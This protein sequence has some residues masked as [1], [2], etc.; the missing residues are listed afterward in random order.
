MTLRRYLPV[1]GLL[2]MLLVLQFQLW[3]PNRIKDQ[4]Q[5]QSEE[6]VVVRERIEAHRERNDRLLEEIRNAH[7]LEA[8]EEKARL[9]LGMVREDETFLFVPEGK[10]ASTQQ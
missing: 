2:L 10:R 6:K 4:L 7:N 5:V 3:A 9:H 8:I 1:A